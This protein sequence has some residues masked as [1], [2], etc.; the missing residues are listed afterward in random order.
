MKKTLFCMVLAAAALSA[1]GELAVERLVARQDWP[2]S[3]PVKAVYVLAGSNAEN[4]DVQLV[5]SNGTDSYEIPFGELSGDVRSVAAGRE[6]VLSWDPTASE[7][8]SAAWLK[9]N[10]DALSFSLK[11][12]ATW[13]K[14]LV[15]DLSGGAEALSWPVTAMSE[16]PGCGWTD[17]YKTTNLVLRHVRVYGGTTFNAGSPLTEWGRPINSSG[18][19][20]AENQVSV[21]LT[22][23]FYM[24]VFELTERQYELIMGS[25]EFTATK[26]AFP[27]GSVN[28]AKLRGTLGNSSV[29]DA[30]ASL[31]QQAW[32]YT[33]NVE[34][35]SLVYK[36]QSKVAFG[37]LVPEGWKFDLPTEALWEYACRAGSTGPWGNGADFA[38][39]L[40]S[41]GRY[42][43]PSVEAMA[44]HALNSGN[45]SHAVG[46][47][48]PNSWDLYDMHGNVCE[49]C[50]DHHGGGAN[51]TAGTEPRGIMMYD[52][53]RV[54]WR[55]LRGG[56]YGG[57][58][59]GITDYRDGVTNWVGTIAMERS[60]VRGRTQSISSNGAGVGVRLAVWHIKG[61]K[62]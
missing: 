25:D 6:C 23:D 16:R 24:G 32:P 40:D 12:T 9:A 38:L 46:G 13:P 39:Y 61:S 35:G 41:N 17:L 1:R 18:V 58:M 31:Y 59:L 44:W 27:K 52:A 50:L 48:V 14:Y 57:S 2:W 43:D 49:M 47:K 60:A 56:D 36:L 11:L 10:K 34:E 7:T 20:R 5:V 45:A 29:S 55:V 54:G 22:N 15:L 8:V 62:D 51:A 28:W 53:Y 4:A 42:R 3:A 37:G 26:P 30:T 19:G 21:T 33:A